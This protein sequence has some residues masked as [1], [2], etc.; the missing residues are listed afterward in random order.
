MGNLRFHATLTG[1]PVI[2]RLAVPV[3]R[4]SCIRQAAGR[5]LTPTFVPD[6]AAV[7]SLRRVLMLVLDF[8]AILPVLTAPV[9]RGH[10]LR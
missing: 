10:G 6:E 8:R 7:S 5:R 9:A 2:V 3:T 1:F 4:Q